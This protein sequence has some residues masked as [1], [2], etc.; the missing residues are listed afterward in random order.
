M[1]QSFPFV[2]A[3]SQQKGGVGKTTA[4]LCIAAELALQGN[5]CLLVDLSS[6][7]NLTS[8]LGLQPNQLIHSSR[9]L[10]QNGISPEKLIKS[11]AING[12]NIIPANQTLSQVVNLLYQQADHDQAL[13]KTFASAAFK[14][15][16]F[17]VLDCPPGISPL[18][19]N[20]MAAADLVIVPLECEFFTLDVLE[21]MFQMITLSRAK[22]NPRL[23]YRLLITKMDSQ[24]SHHK[25]NCDQIIQHYK[26]ALLETT[27]TMD[28]SI[29]QS[30]LEGIPL[31]VY[32]PESQA[33][34][35]FQLLTKEILSLFDHGKPLFKEIEVT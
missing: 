22:E 30:Q 32:Q 11:T 35:Q 7:G 27:I 8:A 34:Q 18:I 6:T 9:D 16:D 3:I 24:N 17:I 26:N 14:K 28:L 33:S 12:L 13:R 31:Q 19:E 23:A 4:A 21:N 2:I 15:Y 5:L 20:A 1:N 29:P 25:E 10:F